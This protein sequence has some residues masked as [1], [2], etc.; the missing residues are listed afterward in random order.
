MKTKTSIAH[1]TKEE[2]EALTNLKEKLIEVYNPLLIY[3]IAIE[4]TH[5]LKRD[6]L[7]YP[8]KKIKTRFAI[9]VLVIVP[10]SPI[11]F[12]HLNEVDKI[13]NEISEVNLITYPL[14]QFQKELNDQS[15][16]FCAIQKRSKILYEHENSL[17]ELPTCRFINQTY[18]EKLLK[19]NSQY[20]NYKNHRV[21]TLYFSD[22]ENVTSIYDFFEIPIL[23]DELQHAFAKL[24]KQLG[25]KA[26]NVSLRKVILEYAYSATEAGVNNDFEEI[27][28][29]FEYL[30]ELF[31]VAERE[32]K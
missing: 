1:F 2:Q 5:S 13:H 12:S 27:L 19:Y 10:D 31:D 4:N 8:I 9:D 32:F 17:E 30:M 16:F 3:L 24:L 29:N 6:S 14:G 18:K 23:S 21:E 7:S 15:V 25:A 20:P 26:I 11:L 28:V 22:G